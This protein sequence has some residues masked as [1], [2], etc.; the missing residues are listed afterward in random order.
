MQAHKRGRADVGQQ[1]GVDLSHQAQ[2][3]GG[4][5]RCA[6]VARPSCP[7]GRRADR[8]RLGRSV[9]AARRLRRG[10]QHEERGRDRR[11][12]DQRAGWHPRAAGRNQL[13]RHARHAGG[14]PHRGGATDS[15][16]QGGRRVRRVPQPGRAG[17]DGG[18]PQIRHPVHGL[19]RVVRSDHRQGLSRGVP[20][21]AGGVADRR[22]DRP[23]DC[24]RGLQERRDHRRE[25]RR[26]PGRPHAGAAGTHQGRN[27]VHRGGCR[28]EPDRFH[29]ADTALQKRGA[30]V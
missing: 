17:R 1:D 21:R 2:C 8:N 16:E 5:G 11:G 9:V 12:G 26:R 18:L 7:R 15:A 6:A 4:R 23:V 19:R 27:Q 20:Q 22:Y 10:H 29:R 30:A 28:S 24:R 14:R 3:A 25:G 13:R